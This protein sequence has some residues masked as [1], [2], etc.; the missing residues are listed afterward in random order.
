[1]IKI[2]PNI[3]LD[4]RE[5]KFQFIRSAGPGGQNVNKVATAVQLKFNVA[6]SGSLPEGVRARLGDVAGNRINTAG[7]MVITA[8]RF[9]TQDANRRDAIDRLVQLIRRAA[10]PPRKRKPTRPS[11][12][13]KRRRLESKRR[14]SDKKRGR[15]ADYSRD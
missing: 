10:V 15:R 5:L 9:R 13:A 12:A 11:R 14:Q 7:D 1:M 6:G 8:R 3:A 4:E 2:T